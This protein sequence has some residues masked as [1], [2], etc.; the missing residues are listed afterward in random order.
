MLAV[1]KHHPTTL[2]SIT[3]VPSSLSELTVG[4]QSAATETP[5]A[6]SSAEHIFQFIK[7][8]PQQDRAQAISNA[9]QNQ[10]AVS[11]EL[12]RRI[13]MRKSVQDEDKDEGEE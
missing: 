1:P 5:Q 10:A 2:A 9:S 4:T 13:R 6:T 7:T 12:S 3:P 8:I 11:G